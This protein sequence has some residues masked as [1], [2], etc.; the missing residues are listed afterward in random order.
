MSGKV[1]GDISVIGGSKYSPERSLLKIGR[2]SAREGASV[3][4]HLMVKGEHRESV[5]VTVGACDPAGHL[6]AEIG[7]RKA[8]RNGTAYLIPLTVTVD[9]D[10]PQMNRL[11]GIDTSLGEIMLETTHPT[12]KEVKL[13]VRFAVE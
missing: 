12:A 11:G 3:K 4:L 8:I 7:E 10:T 5:K 6:I 13:R 9:K 2:V 1:A